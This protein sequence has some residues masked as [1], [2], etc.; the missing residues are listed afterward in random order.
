MPPCPRAMGYDAGFAK[1]G[2]A[3][4]EQRGAEYW[5]LQLKV[6]QTKKDD[7]AGKRKLRVNEDDKER[8]HELYRSLR[9]AMDTWKPKAMAVETFQAN[10]KQGRTGQGTS[11]R[12]FK[13]EQA[14]AAAAVL[15]WERDIVVLP[16]LPLDLKKPLT[17]DATATKEDVQAWVSEHVKGAREALA[18]IRAKTMH[19]HA[20]DAVGH[21]VL[22]LR[23][24]A[25][26]RRKA[27]W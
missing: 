10:M 16:F 1:G 8:L 14:V 17:G 4:V 20:S 23:E 3:V 13:T 27:Q 19:E 18:A 6:Y 7:G 15:A 24:I 22:A 11:A 25:E 9:E 12:A 26:I 5:L 2:W 21:A